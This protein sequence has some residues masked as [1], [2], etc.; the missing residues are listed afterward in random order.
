MSKQT[1]EYLINEEVY[2]YITN[3]ELE[4]DGK[5]RLDT[6]FIDNLKADDTEL[7]RK[8]TRSWFINAIRTLLNPCNHKFHH[9]LVLVSDCDENEVGYSSDAICEFMKNFFIVNKTCYCYF[10]SSINLKRPSLGVYL[11]T[12]WAYCL[13]EIKDIPQDD[14]SA[15]KN[16]ME[17]VNEPLRYERTLRDE[18]IICKPH[19]C[20]FIPTENKNLL[21]QP[22]SK[23]NPLWTIHCHATTDELCKLTNYFSSFV[24]VYQIWAETLHYY[25]QD[26]DADLEI[27]QV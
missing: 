25:L 24:T 3:L 2:H 11:T 27:C 17:L 21:N 15:Y 19:N 1:K 20:V 12:N 16:F 13:N 6:L 26:P 22:I 7:T 8:M 10:N 14:F 4:W 23:D 18:T 5:K 9:L